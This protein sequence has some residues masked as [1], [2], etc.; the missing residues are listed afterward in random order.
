MSI[1][2]TAIGG[3]IGA[4]GRKP[5]IPLFQEINPDA[6]QK[7]TIEGNR[8]AV[9]GAA[10]L[11]SAV[12]AANRREGLKS[13]EA[14]TPGATNLLSTGTAQLQAMLRGQL[15]ADVRMAIEQGAASRAAAGGFGGTGAAGALTA[16]DLGTTSLGLIEKGLS[17]A[18]SWLAGAQQLANPSGLFNLSSMFY[19]PQERLQ[20]SQSERNMR[21][22]RD[23]LAEQVAAAPDPFTAAMGREIDRFFNTAASVGMSMAGGGMG[24][25]G[26]MTGGAK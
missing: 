10:N 16:R 3:A 14:T 9:S 5:N 1:L 20:F 25:M 15:P 21:Y 22:Q 7:Q 2:G 8:G 4:F 13:L 23:L 17:S 11:A 26:G 18:E 24:G 6:V 19:S 12:N